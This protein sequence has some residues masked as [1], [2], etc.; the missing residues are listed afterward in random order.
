LNLQLLSTSFAGRRGLSSAVPPAT[1]SDCDPFEG[2]DG[3][4]LDVVRP[5]TGE[6]VYSDSFAA[7]GN[8]AV[9][10]D[11]QGFGVVRV[12]LYGLDGSRVVSA[13]RTAPFT[14]PT[15]DDLELP[16]LFLPANRAI[17]LTSAM[18]AE[19]S[20]HVGF[21]RL[22][23][24]VA[25]IGG[26]DPAGDSR[27]NSV[28]IFDSATFEF[29][30]ESSAADVGLYPAVTIESGGDLLLIGGESA[31]GSRLDGTLAY[32]VEGA[33]ATGALAPQGDLPEPRSRGCVAL[34]DENKG[35]VMGGA[36]GDAAFDT[37]KRGEDGWAFSRAQVDGLDDAAVVGCIALGDGRVFVLGE[38]GAQTGFFQYN[39]D[40]T[41]GFSPIA[42]GHGEQFVAGA[43]LARLDNGHV[44]EVGGADED[45]DPLSRTWEFRAD[46]ASFAPS[47]ELRTARIR[48][49]VARWLLPNTEAVGCG[50][51]D[52]GL[53]GGAGSVEIVRVD[54][55]TGVLV[56][57]DRERPGCAMNVL[58]DGSLLVR[59]GF[60][61]NDAGQLGAVVVVPVLD[62]G[63]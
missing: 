43:T 54:G 4:R 15:G 3:L 13:G 37:M 2:V 24:L 34:S 6:V 45:G 19:R 59:G 61:V 49:D 31:G 40:E 5:E 1:C 35:V 32:T 22:D 41:L 11:L 9:L 38:E 55:G 33:G 51:S 46:E 47:A 53:A 20:S 44:W 18:D 56:G 62:L 42:S 27:F 28:E 26:V 30:A 60:G 57:L 25:L 14:V 23:G 39:G 29:R 7:P 52:D 48:P 50:C 58:P 8:A 21:S 17:P 10:P 63:G 12:E 36:S 16:M